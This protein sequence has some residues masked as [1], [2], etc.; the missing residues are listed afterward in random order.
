MKV[1]QKGWIC[2]AALACM[3]AGHAAAADNIVISGVIDVN[4]ESL[5][6]TKEK[7]TRVS[8]GGLSQS[9]LEFSGTE[10][11]G[12]GNQAFF[13]HQMQFSADTGV[14]PTPRESYVG[15]RG[16]WGALALGRQNT[17][18][19]W[20]VGYADPGWSGDYSRVSNSVFFY[21]PWR[22][23]NAVSYTT[24]SVNGFKGRF[25][26]TAGNE[27]ADHNGRVYSTGVEYRNGPL[28]LG[29]VTDRKDIKNISTPKLES[30]RDNYISAVYRFGGFEPTFIYHTYNGYYAYPPYVGFQTKGWDVQLGAR[31]K[32][33]TTH[34][35]YVSAVSRHDDVG[36][37]LTNGE[38][39]L[40]GY[41]YRFS[42]RTDAYVNYGRVLT[43]G[44]PKVPYP[45]TFNYSGSG[46]P[47]RG[48]QI[49]L[50]HSF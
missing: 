24:P 32:I 4:V 39:I 11:L 26:A 46:N 33:D 14:G 50:R 41:S 20:I 38:S 7:L 35:V 2:T 45:L 13:L 30:S 43:K 16:N 3:A 1:K 28:Y 34:S 27:T 37:D 12:D 48:T 8:S 44:S 47:E 6:T 15:I 40:L 29:Y 5:A 42:K 49:G 19:Y 36:K 18:S 21:A 9:R 10:D 22:E 23:N 25:M 17:P 31:W